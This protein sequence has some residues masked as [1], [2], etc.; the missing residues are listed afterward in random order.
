MAALHGLTVL[1]VRNLW[2]LCMARRVG[3]QTAFW[4]TTSLEWMMA[5]VAPTTYCQLT[6]MC[7][8]LISTLVMGTTTGLCGA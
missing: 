6:R 5:Q 4:C 2:L 8:L 7:S 3:L 1:Y